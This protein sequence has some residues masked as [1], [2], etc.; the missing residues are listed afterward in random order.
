MEI[1]GFIVEESGKGAPTPFFVCLSPDGAKLFV[2]ESIGDIKGEIG[3]G[4]VIA[5]VRRKP[6]KS[7]IYDEGLRG[8]ALLKALWNPQFHRDIGKA[9]RFAD[10]ES[11]EAER[12][13]IMASQGDLMP[14]GPF[15]QKEMEECLGK[16]FPLPRSRFPQSVRDRVYA[17]FDGRC[18]YCGEKIP[19]SKMQVDHIQSRYMNLG[20]DEES[21]YFPS[22][23]V[24]N[25][26]KSFRTLD[27]FRQRI[28]MMGHWYRSDPPWAHRENDAKRIA[29]KYGLDREDHEVEFYFEKVNHEVDIANAKH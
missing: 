20:R 22:C 7:A 3:K 4:L 17:M 15:P 14:I 27:G 16:R 23:A 18:A 24:C 12:K 9:L 13:T 2:R 5:V 25:R 19:E 10:W 1:E 26:V 6:K 28:R 11:A 8:D 29:E 21:N